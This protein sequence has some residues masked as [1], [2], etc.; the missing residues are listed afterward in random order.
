M[1]VLT[2]I[3][4]CDLLHRW[5]CNPIITRADV[6]FRCNTV[7]NGSP[8]R[9]PYQYVMILRVEG[10]QGHSLFALARSTDGFHFEVDPNP[11]MSPSGEPPWNFYEENG[12]EDPRITL[13]DNVYYIMYTAVSPVGFR[14]ALARTLDFET[15]ERLAVVS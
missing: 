13:I 3:T 9:L 4:G 5:S 11:C 8:C 2:R 6:P 12:I 10:Q 15:F 14:I 1:T 7:F